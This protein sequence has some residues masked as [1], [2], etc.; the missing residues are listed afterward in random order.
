MKTTWKTSKET[1]RRGKNRSGKGYL[2]TDD[3]YDDKCMM[4]YKTLVE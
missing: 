2:V 3:D 1:I 4:E